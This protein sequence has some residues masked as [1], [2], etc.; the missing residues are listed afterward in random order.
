MKVVDCKEKKIS[1]FLML[2]T[3]NY[4]K[5][6]ILNSEEHILVCWYMKIPS[7]VRARSCSP[8]TKDHPSSFGFWRQPAG[9]RT[10]SYWCAPGSL[11][12]EIHKLAVELRSSC[13]LQFSFLWGK[14]RIHRPAPT[15][16]V[17]GICLIHMRNLN[18]VQQSLHRSLLYNELKE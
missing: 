15:G 16:A 17:S 5:S 9:Y 3:L 8:E 2:W 12:E 13:V 11:F 10:V 4:L 6:E 7:E 14:G 18:P 1:L